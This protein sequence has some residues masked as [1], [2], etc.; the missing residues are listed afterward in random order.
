MKRIVIIAMLLCGSL[1]SNTILAQVPSKMSYQAVI[2]NSS[3]ELII[4]AAVGLRLSILKASPTGQMV[5]QQTMNP[6][7]NSSGIVSVEFGGGPGFD[8]INWAAGPYFLKTE[9]DPGGGTNYTISGTT[10]LLS[11]PFA[12]HARTAESLVATAP[13]SDSIV[14][15]DTLLKRRIVLNPNMGAIKLLNND[16]VWY[17]MSV[18]S[19]RTTNELLPDGKAI[20]E[21]AIREGPWSG[22]STSLFDPGKNL[23]TENKS[24]SFSASGVIH[25]LNEDRY[26]RQNPTTGLFQLSEVKEVYRENS[27]SSPLLT[28]NYTREKHETCNNLGQVVSRTT[29]ERE[30]QVMNNVEVLDQRKETKEVINP[31]GGPVNVL[32]TT[33]RKVLDEATG[34]IKET[35]TIQLIVAG[36]LRERTTIERPDKGINTRK[37]EYFNEDGQKVSESLQQIDNQTPKITSQIQQ[38]EQG[39]KVVQAKNEI[40]FSP[41]SGSNA[42]GIT[43]QPSTGQF[44]VSAYIGNNQ[45]QLM[46]VSGDYGYLFLGPSDNM[47]LLNGQNILTGMTNF[48]GPVNFQGNTTHNGAM[49][50]FQ[51]SINAKDAFFNGDVQVGTSTQPKNAIISGNATVNGSLAVNGGMNL[52]SSTV[53]VNKLKAN[54]DISVRGP[55]KFVIPHPT[56]NTK[57]L[58]HAAVESNQV[59]N[60][61]VGKVQTNADG[62]ATVTLPT[63]FSNINQNMLIF[64]QL[65]VHGA[66][67]TQAVVFNEYSSSTNSFVIKTSA[68]FTTVSW[69]LMSK[70]NDAYMIAN[71]FTDVISAP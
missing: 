4:N 57:L 10:Q 51:G 20:V 33:V 11:V 45:K 49:N 50:L 12:M 36:K 71:P 27:T 26:Y 21:K 13:E 15:K 54:A 17:E 35:T 61:Y 9:S 55:K 18:K 2:R 23:V 22:K 48:T 42:I 8:T 69:Q 70:R 31:G 43:H 41:V 38:G 37:I 19:P 39:T 68:P 67:F 6:M 3:N 7:S 53:E 44:D 24:L 60:I 59:Y 63:Y 5:Y 47:E 65:T 58:Q 40:V 1:V 28:S 25:T 62:L 52:G 56:D 64:Y 14:L 46:R 34:T 29:F 66:N 30:N 16:T 32:T